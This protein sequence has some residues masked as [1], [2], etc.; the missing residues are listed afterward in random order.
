MNCP[1][2]GLQTLPDQK[3]CRSCGYGLQM[4]T[5][6]LAEYAPLSNLERTPALTSQGEQPRTNRLALWGFTI[7]LIGVA[8][9]VIGKKLMHNEFVAVVALIAS[10]AGMFLAAYPNLSPSRPKKYDSSPSTQP[11]A[12]TPS[13]PTEYLPQ[14]RNIEHIP[15]IT[16]RT[17]DLLKTSAATRPKQKEDGESQA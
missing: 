14:E 3:F 13:R 17:T 7:M 15:S 6:P 2:C 9:A 12:L 16:E 11:E 1:K 4:T 10:L 8:V 5:Q